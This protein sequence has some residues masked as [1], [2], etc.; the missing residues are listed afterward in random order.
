MH[1]TLSDNCTCTMFNV[2]ERLVLSRVVVKLLQQQNVF[3]QVKVQ[4]PQDLFGTPTWPPHHYFR[5]A[6]WRTWRHVKTLYSKSLKFTAT[7]EVSSE[8]FNFSNVIQNI[9][10]SQLLSLT[11]MFDLLLICYLRANCPLE[12]VIHNSSVKQKNLRKIL[13]VI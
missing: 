3:T 4:L 10:V 11:L 9:I 7:K 5:T 13:M 2:C 8:G 6:K 12:L 1:Q